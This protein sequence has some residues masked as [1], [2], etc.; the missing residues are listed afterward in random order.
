MK[1]RKEKIISFF[2]KWEGGYVCHPLDFGGCT[3][4]GVTI[5][6]YRKYF[7]EDKTCKDLK[8][9]SDEEWYTIFEDGYY[10][11]SKADKIKDDRTALLVVDMC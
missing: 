11:P 7:G 6:T 9:I 8:N 5:G 3:M 10:K 4:M 2:K 1:T